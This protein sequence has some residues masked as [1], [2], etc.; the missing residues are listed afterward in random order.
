M[1]GLPPM[2]MLYECKSEQE[3]ENRQIDKQTEGQRTKTGAENQQ[4]LRPWTLQPRCK[5]CTVCQRF[6]LT[7]GCIFNAQVT[8]NRSKPPRATQVFNFTW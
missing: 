1:A 2:L 3:T 5:V 7:I 8:H 6:S 4:K